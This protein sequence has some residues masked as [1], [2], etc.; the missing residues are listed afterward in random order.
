MALQFRSSCRRAGISASY[1][2]GVGEARLR[3]RA[4]PDDKGLVNR[5]G[6]LRIVVAIVV[7]DPL[8]GVG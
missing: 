5:V 7:P 2:Y 8:H 3:V 4:S 6:R 1:G